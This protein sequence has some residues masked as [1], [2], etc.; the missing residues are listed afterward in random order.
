MQLKHVSK[1]KYLDF[2]CDT[3][4]AK[5]PSAAN[6]QLIESDDSQEEV[7]E[8]TF[9][10]EEKIDSEDLICDEKDGCDLSQNDSDYSQNT[11]EVEK[12]ENT[13]TRFQCSYCHYNYAQKTSLNKHIKQMHEENW[14][15]EAS[16]KKSNQKDQKKR[17]LQNAITDS[18]KGLEAY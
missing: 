8:H 13:L 15:L 11:I 4:N 6:D 18:K 5:S 16:S 9:I 17:L 3:A 7:L 12:E 10:K 14:K 1:E 2:S